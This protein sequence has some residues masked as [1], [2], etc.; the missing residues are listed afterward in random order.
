MDRELVLAVLAVLFGGGAVLGSGWRAVRRHEIGDA[1]Y[2]E[3]VLWRDLWWPLLP[4][5][6]VLTA[7]LGWALFEPADAEVPPL[8]LVLASVPFFFLWARALVRA[9]KRTRMPRGD[10]AAFTVGLL[11]PRV[12]VSPSLV[13]TLDAA[14]LGAAREHELAHVRHHD[15]LRVWLV[16]LAADLQWPWP[17]AQQRLLAWRVALELAR[18][19]EARHQ[20]VDGADLAAAI[21]AAARLSH[22]ATAAS[23]GLAE[24]TAIE[25]R[26][27]RLLSPL[28][29]TQ[30]HGFAERAAPVAC[31]LVLL[32]TCITG[33]M[34]GE[35]VVRGLFG[36]GS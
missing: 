33:A 34:W 13:A 30:H 36:G 23:V 3:Q 16:E 2:L 11:R 26:V 29:P 18:D 25:E 1:R 15:P 12:V 5:G 7:L 32:A 28:R 24:P 4:L 20:G 10:I 22:G 14:A 27:R 19:E 31:M 17:A 8:A 9:A 6:A 35:D 21:L